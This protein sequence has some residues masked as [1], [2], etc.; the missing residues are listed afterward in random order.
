MGCVARRF[1]TAE[2]AALFRP[3]RAFIDYNLPACA[4][5]PQCPL[6]PLVLCGRSGL[7]GTADGVKVGVDIGRTGVCAGGGIGAGN[8]Q[9]GKDAAAVRETVVKLGVDGTRRLARHLR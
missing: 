7:Q 8:A 3:T 4:G 5:A 2:G 1:H 9:R 6:V